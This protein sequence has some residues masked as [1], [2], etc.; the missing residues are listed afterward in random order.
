M[1]QVVMRFDWFNGLERVKFIVS[2]EAF[3]SKSNRGEGDPG[4]FG[5]CY[6]EA[7]FC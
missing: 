5:C 2:S 1:K 3:V 6:D 4:V 7:W